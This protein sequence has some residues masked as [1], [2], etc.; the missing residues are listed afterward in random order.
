M[1]ALLSR[2][3]FLGAGTAMLYTALVRPEVD[4]A[5]KGIGKNLTALLQNYSFGD[6]NENSLDKRTLSTLLAGKSYILAFGFNECPACTTIGQNLKAIQDG[7]F[8][9]GIKDIPIVI[10]NVLPEEDKKNAKDYFIRYCDGG[11]IRPKIGI[12]KS[13]KEIGE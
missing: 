12:D 5:G 8:A 6:Q 1:G 13:G 10:V 3:E 7:L 2:R 11:E 9:R 4:A